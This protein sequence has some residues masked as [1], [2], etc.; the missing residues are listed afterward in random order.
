MGAWRP[1]ER[2]NRMG[3][4]PIYSDL[5]VTV[6]LTL[7][8]VY[9]LALRQTQG[10]M[11]SLVELLEIDLPVPNYSTLSR[12]RPHLQVDLLRQSRS[13]GMLLLVDST[14]LKLYGEG[15][16]KVRMHCVTKRITWRKAHLG[17]A[18]ATSEVRAC[19]VTEQ[20]ASRPLDAASAAW[21]GAGA[22][23]AGGRRQ[24]L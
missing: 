10:L 2:P 17:I 21:E 19:V 14:G 18:E 5:A 13:E 23:R 20:K 9:N 12:H 11:E 3:R 6:M 1:S 7:Q 22:T 8:A 4:T 15:K 16:W 24:G